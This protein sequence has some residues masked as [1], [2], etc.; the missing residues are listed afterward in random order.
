MI[1]IQW[2]LIVQEITSPKIMQMG[3]QIRLEKKTNTNML[4]GIRL[5][6]VGN[7]LNSFKNYISVD[8]LPRKFVPKSV[9]IY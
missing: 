8:T 3:R 2:C 1:I 7:F 6:L 9:Q 5:F 4:M